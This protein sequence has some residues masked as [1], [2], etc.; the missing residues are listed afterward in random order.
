MAAGVWV[1]MWVGGGAGVCWPWVCTCDAR[2][3]CMSHRG[4]LQ[5]WVGLHMHPVR[6]S[7]HVHMWCALQ[8]ACRLP[9]DGSPLWKGRAVPVLR[10]VHPAPARQAWH[11]GRRPT[12]P[13]SA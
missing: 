5:G 10:C 13:G 1:W 7:C 4:M 6:T 3:A 9:S 11:G 12:S 8:C 2:R